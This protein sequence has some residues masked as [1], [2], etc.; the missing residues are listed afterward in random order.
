MVDA[1]PVD[2]FGS[3]GF[4]TIERDNFS[5]APEGLTLSGILYF[6]LFTIPWI[7]MAGIIVFLLR[8]KKKKPVSSSIDSN[9]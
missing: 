5:L 4:K 8:G 7:I 3:P 1:M 9:P 6:L 2:D